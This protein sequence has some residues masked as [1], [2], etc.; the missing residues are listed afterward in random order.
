M[1]ISTNTTSTRL[2][3]IFATQPL[4]QATK[5]K[6]LSAEKYKDLRQTLDSFSWESKELIERTEELLIPINQLLEQ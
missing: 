6:S 3:S 2:P 1:I 4:E 5:N